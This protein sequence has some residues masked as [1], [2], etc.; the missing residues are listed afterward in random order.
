MFYL[1]VLAKQNLSTYNFNLLLIYTNCVAPIVV[2]FANNT[3]VRVHAISMVYEFSNARM[4]DVWVQTD[5]VTVHLTLSFIAK[6]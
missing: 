4:Y 2:C 3:N 1:C 6:F 5:T